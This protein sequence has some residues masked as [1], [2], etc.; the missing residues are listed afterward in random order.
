MK[1]TF[2]VTI[3]VE[4]SRVRGN[5]PVPAAA[6]ERVSWRAVERTDMLSSGEAFAAGPDI[7]GDV[8]RG[9]ADAALAELRWR[10]QS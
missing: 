2:V 3:E 8:V 5:P 7:L 6:T 4:V 9:L 10:H 1:R